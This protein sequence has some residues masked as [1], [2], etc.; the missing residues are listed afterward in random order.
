MDEASRCDRVALIQRGQ[1]LAT[2]TPQ[3][4]AASFDRPLFAVHAANRYQAL[5]A[6]RTSPHTHS[7]YPF[8]DTLHYADR[9]TQLPPD[10]VAAEVRA[11]L[12]ARGFADIRV[13]ATAPTV[14]D[15]FMARM[16][17]PEEAQA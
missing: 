12:E 10:V 15:T 1:L 8:G 11:F 14:E 4:I 13:E 7:V 16:G 17:E 2:D 5:L 3:R 9:R 6:L